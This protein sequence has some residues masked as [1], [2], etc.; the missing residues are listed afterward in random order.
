MDAFKLYLA[1]SNKEI[2][3]SLEA[4]QHDLQHGYA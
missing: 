3:A 2:D 4:L 1:F